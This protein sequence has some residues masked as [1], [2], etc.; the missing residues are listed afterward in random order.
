VVFFLGGVACVITIPEFFLNNL[1]FL[2]VYISAS[3]ITIHVLVLLGCVRHLSNR[4][5]ERN[6]SW[7]S[8]KNFTR[9][10]GACSLPLLSTSPLLIQF[11]FWLNE[12]ELWLKE[13]ASLTVWSVL[14]NYPHPWVCLLKMCSYHTFVWNFTSCFR[15]GLLSRLSHLAEGMNVFNSEM[16]V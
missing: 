4:L 16:C 10:A 2:C 11:V 3:P 12:W 13:T 8:K 5:C 7:A 1:D 9:L 14:K 15:L 6:A